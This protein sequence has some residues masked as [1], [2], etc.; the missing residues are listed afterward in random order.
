VVDLLGENARRITWTNAEAGP[1]AAH[2]TT[3]QGSAI[4]VN[5]GADVP[6]WVHMLTLRLR[7]KYLRLDDLF[8]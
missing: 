1:D 3:K 4:E 7:F 2:T 8:R 5:L 6:P